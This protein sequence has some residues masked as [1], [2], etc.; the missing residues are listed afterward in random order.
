[1]SGWAKL[2]LRGDWD[3]RILI[4][5]VSRIGKRGTLHVFVN[6]GPILSI[7]KPIN[8]RPSPSS[9]TGAS[10]GGQSS[11]PKNHNKGCVP[12]VAFTQVGT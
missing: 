2:A 4:S 7:L 6:L 3:R 5:G 8:I 12:D 10:A 1:M 11:V 9:T